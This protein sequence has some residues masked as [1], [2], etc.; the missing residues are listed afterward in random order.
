MMDP[1]N[2]NFFSFSLSFETLPLFLLSSDELLTFYW[3]N[4]Q[5]RKTA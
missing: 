2:T 3:T 4:M 5:G 1:G